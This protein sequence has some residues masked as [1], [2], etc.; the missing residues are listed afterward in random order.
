MTSTVQFRFGGI[1]GRPTAT[2]VRRLRYG[3]WPD[4]TATWWPRT[5][6]R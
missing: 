1:G 4:A 5:T 6:R 3:R 2:A